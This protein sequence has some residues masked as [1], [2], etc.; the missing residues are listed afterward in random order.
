[1]DAE[2]VAALI[3]AQMFDESSTL[4]HLL[5]ASFHNRRNIYGN[6]NQ[7]MS[8]ESGNYDF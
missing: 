5:Q 1:M 8:N 6:T 7:V 3:S 4:S 2:I